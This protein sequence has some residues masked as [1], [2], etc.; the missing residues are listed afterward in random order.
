MIILVAALYVDQLDYDTFGPIGLASVQFQISS[1]LQAI[2]APL[3]PKS[4]DYFDFVLYWIE[5]DC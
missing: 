3:K 2:L 1:C 4:F 5:I